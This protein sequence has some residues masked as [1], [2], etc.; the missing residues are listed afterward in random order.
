MSVSGMLGSKSV[1]GGLKRGRIV[2]ICVERL[3][4]KGGGKE[5]MAWYGIVKRLLA[6]VRSLRMM[7]AKAEAK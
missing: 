2:C 7:C 4:M 3:A 1:Y 5:M 6:A